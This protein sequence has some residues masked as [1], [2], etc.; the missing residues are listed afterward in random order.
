MVE[1]KK[2]KEGNMKKCGTC[3]GDVAGTAKTC[4]HCGAVGPGEKYTAIG[5][6]VFLFVVLALGTFCRYSLWST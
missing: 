4:P 6:V 5:C 2:G 3:G 1:E